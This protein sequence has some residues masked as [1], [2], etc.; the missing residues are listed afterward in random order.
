VIGRLR[1][2]LW[3]IVGYLLLLAGVLFAFV[4][5]IG[6]RASEGGSSRGWGWP[7]AIVLLIAVVIVAAGL[8]ILSSNRF[9][10][11]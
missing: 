7:E 2:W 3:R 10:K 9:V 8:V 4:T 1:P 6:L 11:R 5:L